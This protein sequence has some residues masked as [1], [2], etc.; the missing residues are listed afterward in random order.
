MSKG[1]KLSEILVTV[2]VS[3]VF[4]VIY[5]LW[6]FVYNGVQATGLHLEQLN[7]RGSVHGSDSSVIQL[8][9]NQVLLYVEFAAGAGETIIMGRFD[10]PTIVYAF[11]QGLA[12]ELVFA[13]FKYQSRS[14]MVAMLAGFCT[15]IAAFPIDYFYG[16]LNEVAGWNL[17]LFIVFRLISGAELPGVLSYL[18]V[19]ALDKTGVTKLFRPAAKEDYD[20][21]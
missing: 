13:I 15:A 9:Q 11:I 14:V 7:K 17:T 2:I 12:C 21:L 1:L 6:W 16:Y 20:N 10:I 4:A 19:K 8:F 3:V 5:N 18:L